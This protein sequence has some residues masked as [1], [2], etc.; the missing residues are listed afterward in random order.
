MQYDTVL[1]ALFHIYFNYSKKIAAL[2]FIKLCKLHYKTQ[3]L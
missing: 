2:I 1:H 3:P